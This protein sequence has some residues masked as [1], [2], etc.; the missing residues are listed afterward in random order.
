MVIK[1]C[2]SSPQCYVILGKSLLGGGLTFPSHIIKGSAYCFLRS[3][4]V[5]NPTSLEVGR[6]NQ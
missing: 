5:L 2:G 4:P 3:P 6:L 1:K